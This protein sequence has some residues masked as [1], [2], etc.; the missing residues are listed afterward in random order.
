MGSAPRPWRCVNAQRAPARIPRRRTE[1]S[2]ASIGRDLWSLKKPRRPRP[3]CRPN[4][5]YA[6]RGRSTFGCAACNSTSVGG[7][8]SESAPTSALSPRIPSGTPC[9][10]G[11]RARDAP[12]P[13]RCTH[14]PV[15]QRFE[16]RW[17]R[18]RGLGPALAAGDQPARGRVPHPR[19]V[20]ERGESGGNAPLR[21]CWTPS[22]A[23]VGLNDPRGVESISPRRSGSHCGEQRGGGVADTG[24]GHATTVADPQAGLRLRPTG[25][26]STLHREHGGNR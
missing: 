8:S 24:R 18:R 23:G 15:R 12:R 22:G 16:C 2:G 14:Q 19:P 25:R 9:H 13:I 6:R 4:V 10:H 3:S 21:T 11:T 17:P 5:R 20:A 1:V 26:D 7:L